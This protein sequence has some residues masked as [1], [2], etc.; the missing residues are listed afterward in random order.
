MGP[1]R[2]G[3]TSKDFVPQS[4]PTSSS[5]WSNLTCMSAGMHAQA[6]HTHTHTHTH[7]PVCSHPSATARREPV[8]CAQEASGQGTGNSS[9]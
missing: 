9:V 4:C 2:D 3:L 7:V 8:L 5:C 1:A 6:H